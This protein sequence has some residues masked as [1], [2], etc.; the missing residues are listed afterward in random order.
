MLRMS[1]WTLFLLPVLA[2]GLFAGTTGKLTGVVTDAETGDPLPGVNVVIEGTSYGAITNLEGR[3][4]IINLQPGTYD[5]RFSM[6]GYATFRVRQVKVEI[7]RTTETNQAIKSQT[8]E[9][10]SV[11]VVA[12]RPVVKRDISSSQV[13]IEAKSVETMPVQTV[14]QVLVLQ[15]GI[16]QGSEGILVRGGS[17]NQTVMMLDGLSLNDERSNIPYAAISVSAVKEIQIQTGGFN[18][19]YGNVRSGLVNVITKE[20]DARRYNFAATLN[21]SPASAKHFGTSLYDPMSFFNR[22]YM[23]PAVCYTGT[24][25]GAW[26]DYT[27][28]QYPN[29]D[30]W[31]AVA[32]K[33]LQNADPSDDLTAEGAKRLY[34]WQHRRQGDIKKPDYV[35]DL[36]FGG[37][38]PLLS[39]FGGTRFFISHFREQEM[40][41]FPLSRDGYNENYT[42]LKLTTDLSRNMKLMYT[43]LYGEVYSASP[44]NWTTT[45]T[46]RVLRDQSEIADL[47]NSTDGGAIL[48]VP[49]YYSPSAIYRQVH[50]LK[51]THMLSPKTFYEV[52]LEYQN[53][54]N[55]TYEMTLRD[56]SKVYEIVNGYYVD[57]MPY[58]YWGYG[59]NSINGDRMG[60]W[61]N[62]GRDKSVNS[63][64]SF[65][66]NLTS[67]VTSRHQIKTG[68]QVVYND[69]DVN[70]G[71]V[72]PSNNFWNRSMTYN[73]FPFRVGAFLQ[74][75]IE[76]EG[77]VANIGVRMDH[78]N[79]NTKYM[80]VEAYDVNLGA[81]YGQEITSTVE[82]VATTARTYW[83]PRL[84]I[85]HPITNN[86]KLYFNYGH[87]RSEPYSSYRFRLQQE[88]NGLVTYLGNPNMEMEKTVSY[89]LG[90]SQSLFNTMLL[91]VAAHYK[92]VSNQAGWVYYHNFKGTV[93][94]YKASNNN[95]ADIRGFEVTLNKQ[96][97]DWIT[98]FV[99]Y[100]YEVS[101]T[102]Y[103]GLIRNYENPNQQ[104]AYLRENLY[105]ERPH[106]RP[107]ARANVDLHTPKGFGP[108]VAGFRPLESINVSLLGDWRAGG[109]VTYNPNNIP[110]VADNVRWKDWF[111]LD[112]RLSKALRIAGVESQFYLDFSN[113]LNIKYLYYASFADNYD[114]IDYLESLNLDWE[115]GDEKGSDK[116]GELRPEDVKYDPL[117]RNPYNDPEITKR[118]DKR[119]ESKSYIDNPNID[120]LWWLHPRDITFG[121]RINF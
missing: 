64:T 100:T 81:G 77:F 121:I 9:G 52:S 89:E 26:D 82:K 51:L 25:N 31:Q 111:N 47:L 21:Y 29:F 20:G 33:T 96:S 37:P 67:Q 19:E 8:I 5:L 93:D 84:G 13:N 18:A 99:N 54:R 42:Q 98:G 105:Q 35:V 119:K 63:T 74:D 106:P 49:G 110:G 10:E 90:Y 2:F 114:Y 88:S 104:R 83:S 65:N 43:G 23:D 120:S 86:S 44:Y 53:N 102:G 41:I 36:G 92:D 50:G 66:A 69:Y 48:Y 91:N 40:F 45:P 73:V 113:V 76:Y 7:D 75:K 118:N 12:Q 56:T 80:D 61:M 116:I 58:G 71:T 85:S 107:Y 14:R 59:T 55:N 38:V 101:T 4:T 17:A 46:G 6:I 27:R 16:Q 109:Y 24:D 62:L 95:Y 78:T 1:K 70:S 60:G 15:A 94:Y 79:P 57:E 108:A 22:V 72:S 11:V 112:L 34:E 32:D 3:Y 39:Q 115:K 68:A 103:F 30:G 87:F 117:E 28:S 97:G